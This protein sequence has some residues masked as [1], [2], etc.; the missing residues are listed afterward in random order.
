MTALTTYPHLLPPNATPLEKA[1]SGPTGR[2]TQIPTPLRQLWRWDLCQVEHLP[3]LA[4][5]M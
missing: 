1:L 2:I 4:W 3:L 5:T